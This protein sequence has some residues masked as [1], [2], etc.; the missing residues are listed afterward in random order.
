MIGE[1]GTVDVGGAIGIKNS[2]FDLRN[3]GVKLQYR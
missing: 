3:L 2:D 1:S